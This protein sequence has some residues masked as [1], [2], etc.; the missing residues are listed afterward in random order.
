MKKSWFSTN[1]IFSTRLV[2]AFLKCSKI[3]FYVSNCL[4]FY[5]SIVLISNFLA[6]NFGRLPT[7]NMPEEILTKLYLISRGCGSLRVK[8]TSIYV[9]IGLFG[10]V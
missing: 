1:F 6:S 7:N 3:A 4:D 5:F 8:G 10:V 9:C 2:S